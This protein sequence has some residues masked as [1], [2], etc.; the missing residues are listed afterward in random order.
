V[1]DLLAPPPGF[2]VEIAPD[3]PTLRTSRLALQQVLLNLIGNAIKHRGSGSTVGRVVVSVAQAAD[4]RRFHEFRVTD[5]GP[6]IDPR[7]HDRIFAIFQ[8][9]EPRD[10]VE[11]TGIGLALVRKT[12]EHVGGRVRVES[13]GPGTGATFAFT[14]PRHD[15]LATTDPEALQHQ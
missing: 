10:K 15:A 6:G 13:A 9:L 1:I 4:P 7:Y 5:D 3:M 2:V 8:T 14:W 12:V 11:G